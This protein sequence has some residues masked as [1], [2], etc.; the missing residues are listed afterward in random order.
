M[1]GKKDL[2]NYLEEL[3]Q[4]IQT[5]N[6]DIIPKKEMFFLQLEERLKDLEQNLI[7]KNNSSTKLSKPLSTFSEQ[8]VYG[9]HKTFWYVPIA[10]SIFILLGVGLFFNIKKTSHDEFNSPALERFGGSF[11]PDTHNFDDKEINHPLEKELLKKIQQEE[12][13]EKKIQYIRELIKFY[14]ETNQ[15]EKIQRLLELVD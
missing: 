6:Q 7:E 9:K 2:E 14:K 12:D 13:P 4:Y 1:N 11:K 10:A 15:H 3:K 8:L 5:K